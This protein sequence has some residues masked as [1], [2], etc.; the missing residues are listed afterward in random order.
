MNLHHL[1]IFCM[2]AENKSFAKA[3]AK[4]NISQPAISQHV[5][6]LEAD[7]GKKLIERKGR[8]FRLTTHGETLFEYGRRIFNMVEEAENALLRF[9]HPRKRIFLGATSITGTY[10]LPAFIAKFTEMNPY[11]Q[12]NVSLEEHTNEL[13]ENII[14]NEIDIAITYETVILKDDIQVSRIIQDEFVLV[15]PGNHP[16]ASGQLVSLEEIVT[17]PFIFYNQDH[18]IQPILEST[19]S[20]SSVNVTLQLSQL[21]AVKN[22]ISRGLGVSMLPLS[23]IR[24]EVDHGLLAVANCPAFRVPRYLVS[25]HK[26]MNHLPDLMELALNCLKDKNWVNQL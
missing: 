1:Y 3:A 8:L 21:E 26:K 10:F 4:V 23:S 19:L 18:F 20:G 11:V 15:L 12:F 16:W 2:V 9:G 25:M 6:K 7:L 24:V 5:Q 22:A 13:L 14:K 17:L